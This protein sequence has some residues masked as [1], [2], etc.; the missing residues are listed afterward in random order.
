MSSFW[1][2]CESLPLGSQIW[3]DCALTLILLTWRIWWAPN[4]AS[5]WEMGYNL[6]F[7]GLIVKFGCYLFIYLKFWLLY[8]VIVIVIVIVRRIIIIII[9]PEAQNWHF[10]CSCTV[11]SPY[12]CKY[13]RKYT[14]S[15]KVNVCCFVTQ[16]AASTLERK[17]RGIEAT[18]SQVWRMLHKVLIEQLVF[19]WVA[20][21]LMFM[22]QGVSSI[23]HVVPFAVFWYLATQ[24]VLCMSSHLLC[25]DTLRHK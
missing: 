6:A 16:D 17:K 18:C 19:Y 24:V 8:I 15:L 3:H 9:M 4:N 25:S 20:S 2:W 1:M 22:T 7:K 11:D 5:S 13:R 12:W 14:H 10:V 21:E 23:V